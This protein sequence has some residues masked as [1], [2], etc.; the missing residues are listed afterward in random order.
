VEAALN[1]NMKVLGVGS[2][3]KNPRA[4]IVAGS[5]KDIDLASIIA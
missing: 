2:A 1:G 4:T 3:A 5:L